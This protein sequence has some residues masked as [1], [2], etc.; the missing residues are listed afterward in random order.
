MQPPFGL[1]W[2][3]LGGG[4]IVLMKRGQKG[5]RIKDAIS[6]VEET[7]VGSHLHPA[8]AYLILTRY[9]NLELPA[10]A[11]LE[12]ET[13]FSAEVALVFLVRTP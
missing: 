3:F 5:G 12:L 4:E 1:I 9:P 7:C 10:P 13:S 11:S 8:F 6:G 2:W